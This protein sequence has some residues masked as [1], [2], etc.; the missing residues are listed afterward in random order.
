MDRDE[1]KSYFGTLSREQILTLPLGKWGDFELLDVMNDFDRE[2]DW[3]RKAAV[4]EL[5]LRSPEVADLDYGMFCWD[6]MTY[7][8][9]ERDCAAALRWA[10]ALIAYSEQHEAG[11]NRASNRRELAAIYLKCD[12]LDT[13]LTIFTRLVQADPTDIWNYNVLALILPGVGLS[14][15]ALEVLDRALDLV[16]QEDPERLKGQLTSLRHR[17]AEALDATPSRTDDLTPAVLDEFR[18]ALLSSQPDSSSRS[19]SRDS[20]VPY[21]PPVAQLITADS[22]DV[23]ALTTEIL[24]QGKVL[25]PELVQMAF[26]PDLPVNSAPARAIEILRSL[27]DAHPADFGELSTWLDQA[28]GDWRAALLTRRCGKVGGYTTSELEAIASNV[29]HAFYVRSSATA[30]LVERAERMPSQRKR[31]VAF[32]RTLLTRPE[33]Y[34]ADEETFLGFLISDLLDLDARELYTDI[35]QAF[36]EDR[37]DTSIVDLSYVH[38][39]WDLEPVSVPRRRD[40]G[41]YL[42]LRCTA[43]DRV[44]EHFVQYVQLDIGTMEREAEGHSVAYDPYIMDHEIVCPKCGAVDQYAMTPQ[45]YLSL[46]VQ[47]K[48]VKDIA[49]I[50]T[51]QK[52]ISDLPLNPRVHPFR[53]SV[54]G[55]PMH[56]LA[57]LEEY[58]RRIAANPDDAKLV[59]RMGTLLRTLYRYSAALEAHRQ[60]Y[61]MDPDDV[62]IVLTRAL[63]EH[64]LG[65]REA[66]QELYE[67]VLTVELGKG[68]LLGRVFRPSKWASTAAEGLSLLKK[69]QPSPWALPALDIN[70]GQVTEVRPDLPDSKSQKQKGKR[71]RRRKRKRKRRK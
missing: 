38:D 52:S 68:N 49:E 28:E 4:G 23:P 1:I 9:G 63:S 54:F 25:A 66:A 70:T 43:C 48:G 26:D 33:A 67:Q 53:S 2:K 17:V 10:H 20:A 14:H 6:V 19:A 36:V 24:A 57:G 61:D 22:S 11:R 31:I 16:A 21:L 5:I 59:M 45:A 42:R 32:M 29:E 46:R 58:R 64:D 50:L 27:R 71:K 69:R 40:D 15:L 62:E 41:L 60:A 55:E 7:Y 39:Y 34:A 47:S 56:P 18:A 37:V 8:Q 51:G 3:D 13:G 44:R 65:D 35:E 12:D 30:S